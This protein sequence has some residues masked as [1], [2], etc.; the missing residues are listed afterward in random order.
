MAVASAFEPISRFYDS[1][2]AGFLNI[3]FFPMTALTVL[4]LGYVRHLFD[5]FVQPGAMKT[6]DFDD[7]ADAEEEYLRAFD[8]I[9]ATTDIHD[10][11]SGGLYIGNPF[12]LQHPGRH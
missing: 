1:A 3:L 5:G 4:G 10:P 8:E 9:N 11:R 6:G 2:A 12:S 7:L